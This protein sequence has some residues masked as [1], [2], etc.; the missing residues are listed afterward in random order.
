M[1]EMFSTLRNRS[2]AWT[3]LCCGWSCVLGFGLSG[4]RTPEPAPPPFTGPR[5][6]ASLIYFVGT[7]LTGPQ[8]AAQNFAVGDLRPFRVSVLAREKRLA[9]SPSGKSLAAVARLYSAAHDA[10]LLR[11]LSYLTG[12]VEVILPSAEGAAPAVPPAAPPSEDAASNVASRE[13]SSVV[14]LAEIYG[15]LPRGVSADFS[16]VGLEGVPGKLELHFRRK[17]SRAPSAP[18]AADRPEAQGAPIADLIE[19]TLVLE[20]VMTLPQDDEE[21]EREK[22]KEPILAKASG[23]DL[24]KPND[25]EP[26][27]PMVLLR[28]S[29]LLDP[30]RLEPP[31]KL[32]LNIPSPF[33]GQPGEQITLELE[34]TQGAPPPGSAEV[35][36][37]AAELQTV[38]VSPVPKNAESPS[39]VPGMAPALLGLASPPEQRSSLL[40][41]AQLCGSELVEDLALSSSYADLNAFAEMLLPRLKA[42]EGKVDTAGLAFLLERNAYYFLNGLALKDKLASELKAIVVKHTGQGGWQPG[43]LEDILITS[44]TVDELHAR[45]VEENY[46]ALEDSS[47]AARARAFD[48]LA[49]Q[50][51]APEGFQPLGPIKERRQVLDKFLEAA[52]AAAASSEGGPGSTPTPAV[53][54]A[55]TP[56]PTP[57]PATGSPASAPS[58]TQK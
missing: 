48:W 58:S 29:S 40:F 1:R 17:V 49:A 32:Q 12:G 4:C 38:G 3:L 52:E 54:P 20:R 22:E 25:K 36:P 10:K 27:R 55:T 57:P 16:L 35:Q 34:A 14:P 42:M 24:K 26:I 7:P 5:T 31:A 6:S 15:S 13:P 9:P 45:I 28:E 51:K 50:G 21:L 44:R 37:S 39:A 53:A 11:P 43:S 47:P 30:I 56:Q 46:I 41:L 8:G 33:L 19:V 18:G 23:K 2:I